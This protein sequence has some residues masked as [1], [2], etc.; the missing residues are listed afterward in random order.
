MPSYS[1]DRLEQVRREHLRRLAEQYSTTALAEMLG[2]TSGSFI[3]QMCGPRPTR[4]VSERTAREIEA[5]LGL[6]PYLL[7]M[8]LAPVDAPT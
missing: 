5:H 6:D 1:L 3:S 7:D 4:R 2:Y 8:D